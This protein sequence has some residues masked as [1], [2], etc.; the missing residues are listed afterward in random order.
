MTTPVIAR[1]LYM[2][3]P[4]GLAR[5]KLTCGTIAR[6]LKIRGTA[7]NLNTVNKLLEQAEKLGGSG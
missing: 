7:R 4:D 5:P 2:Y 1:E 6:E 3:F